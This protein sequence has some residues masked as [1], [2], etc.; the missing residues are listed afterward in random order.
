MASPSTSTITIL[1]CDAFINSFC[2][3]TEAHGAAELGGGNPEQEPTAADRRG[4]DGREAPGGRV[5][6]RTQEHEAESD[7]A[8]DS[9]QTDT[10]VVLVV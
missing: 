7:G 1:K 3:V 10:A 2:T 5:T 9:G 4:A 8:G 6:R